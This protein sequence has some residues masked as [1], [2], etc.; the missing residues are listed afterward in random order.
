MAATAQN[1]S[2][3]I[4]LGGKVTPE[5]LKS[6][7]DMEARLKQFGASTRTVN[8]V[9]SRACK[10][11]FEGAAKEGTRAFEKLEH[12]SKSA[13][14]KMVEHSR[15]A[16]E[17]I[18]EHFEKVYEFSREMTAKMS[19]FFGIGALI[20]GAAGALTGEELIRRGTEV[21]A[22]REEALDTLAATLRAVVGRICFQATRKRSRSYPSRHRSVTRRR[23]K[24]SSRCW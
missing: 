22:E 11:T 3:D 14:H 7:K 18:K 19:E 16:S 23:P 12:E 15:E 5:V 4:L 2:F 24:N 1:V 17:K 8:A 9:M 13:F 20:G 21:F 6:I 10:E